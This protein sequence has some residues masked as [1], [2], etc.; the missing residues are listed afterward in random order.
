MV[1]DNS[2]ISI[3]CYH[4]TQLLLAVL[5]KIAW[6]IGTIGFILYFW[7]RYDIQKKRADL[8]DEYKLLDILPRMKYDPKEQRAAMRYIINT[9]KTTRSKW[10]SLFI[11]LL[12][13]A[14]L[15]VGIAL[16]LSS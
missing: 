1:L 3:S 9:T 6:Y 8:V 16:D 4:Y 11:F 13:L 2:N 7:H 10:N 12:S 5:G 15:I 14:A